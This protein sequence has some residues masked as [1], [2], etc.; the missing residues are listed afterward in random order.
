MAVSDMWAPSDES[1]SSV[2]SSC[3][4]WPV[5]YHTDDRDL[6]CSCCRNSPLEHCRALVTDHN[7]RTVLRSPLVS[8]TDRHHMLSFWHCCVVTTDKQYYDPPPFT[9]I[10]TN[11][12]N[13]CSQLCTWYL[14]FT[15]LLV[16]QSKHE[17]DTEKCFSSVVKNE[18]KYLCWLLFI[19]LKW[20]NVVKIMFLALSLSQHESWII[21]DGIC[22]YL[23]SR[24]TPL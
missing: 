18:N 12:D 11:S 16:F 10:T 6:C 23:N 21:C 9:L 1:F 14:H 13:C 19:C 15:S 5:S 17:G 24:V 20:T 3:E 7:H 4:T 2:I 22:L 8:T